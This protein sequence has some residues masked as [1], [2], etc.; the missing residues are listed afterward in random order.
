MSHFRRNEVTFSSFTAS[1]SRRKL[2]RLAWIKTRYDFSEAFI[3]LRVRLDISEFISSSFFFHCYFK[4]RWTVQ[5]SAVLDCNS[6]SFAAIEAI[7]F[8]RSGRN[9]IVGR[10]C[11]FDNGERVA[12]VNVSCMR[13]H[14]CVRTFALIEMYWSVFQPNVTRSIAFRLFNC[15]AQVMKRM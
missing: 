14:A 10:A 8:F 4:F 2:E 11:D 3:V 5:S 7:A 13:S 6:W 12:S 15:S 1:M 9:R